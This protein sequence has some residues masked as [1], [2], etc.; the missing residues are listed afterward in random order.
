MRFPQKLRQMFAV[1]WQDM[2]VLAVTMVT[3]LD[4]SLLLQPMGGDE[5]HAALIHVLGVLIVS[6]FTTGYLCGFIASCISVVVINYAFIHPFYQLN[7]HVAGYPLTFFTMF[8][9]SA[10]TSALT[11]QIKAEEETRIA[12]EQ[13]RLRANLLRAVGHDLRTPLTSILGS[14][15]VL[16]DNTDHLNREEIR[17]LLQNM[18]SESEW[19]LRMIE[20]LLSITKVGGASY[21]IQKTPEVV[22][23]V[24]GEVVETFQKRVPDVLLDV[25]VPQ[26]FLEVPMDA[27]LIEQV[28]LNLMENAAIH[29][30]CTEIH[31]RAARKQGDLSIMVSD[32]G[33]GMSVGE[34]N[35]LTSDYAEMASKSVGDKKT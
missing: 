20:N 26:T 4:L 25:T 9:V 6:R 35:T 5:S 14:A 28:L 17:T 15:D 11:S 7:A 3:A 21:R 32:N 8:G 23:E 2:V 1:Q 12:A 27:M 13:E 16:L 29:G 10:I 24:V 18:K 22:E 31:I 19:M 30:N 34:V 33:S